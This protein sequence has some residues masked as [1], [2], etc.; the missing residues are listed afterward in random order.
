MGLQ[1]VLAACQ[2][3]YAFGSSGKRSAK[4]N[5]FPQERLTLPLEIY[6]GLWKNNLIQSLD[7]LSDLVYFLLFWFILFWLF[8]DFILFI[9]F[10][11][12]TLTF[13]AVKPLFLLVWNNEITHIYCGSCTLLC[14]SDCIKI[15]TAYAESEMKR[16]VLYVSL[17]S[18]EFYNNY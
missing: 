9:L 7:P 12:T 15:F 1:P 4:E 16:T 13:Q 17:D 18:Y 14:Y 2:G 5:L 10:A 11:W 6:T 3:A 8:L